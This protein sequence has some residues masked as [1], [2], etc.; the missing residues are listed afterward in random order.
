MSDI[1]KF[2]VDRLLSSEDSSIEDVDFDAILGHTSEKGE[3]EEEKEEEVQ[4]G[5]TVS[6]FSTSLVVRD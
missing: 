6:R 1:L 4:V 3:W 5:N 2:G